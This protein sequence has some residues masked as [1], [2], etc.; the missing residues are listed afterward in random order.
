MWL[1]LLIESS[2]L[3]STVDKTIY[4]VCYAFLQLNTFSTSTYIRKGKCRPCP[5]LTLGDTFSAANLITAALYR[6]RVSSTSTLYRK[7]Y[8]SIKSFLSSMSI[9]VA[10]GDIK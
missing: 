8:E 6:E 2:M 7:L 1:S 5:R 3:T 9:V 4:L 10:N